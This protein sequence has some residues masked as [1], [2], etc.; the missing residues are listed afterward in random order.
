MRGGKVNAEIEQWTRTP[1][2]GLKCGWRELTCRQS[3]TAKPE[4]LT[5]LTRAGRLPNRWPGMPP[6]AQVS[7]V[8]D[9]E[10]YVMRTPTGPA[11]APAPQHQPLSSSW[12][13]RKAIAK[14]HWPEGGTLRLSS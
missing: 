2:D 14:R 10:E 7:R 11:A 13:G 3:P 5:Q 4:L 9:H 1:P 6:L 12:E 8:L